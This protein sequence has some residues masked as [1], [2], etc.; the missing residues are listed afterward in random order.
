MSPKFPS[1]TSGSDRQ[2]SG[3]RKENHRRRLVKKVKSCISARQRPRHTRL[4]E[5]NVKPNYRHDVFH[6]QITK[7]YVAYTGPVLFGVGWAWVDSKKKK[8]R[9]DFTPF[10]HNS[11]TISTGAHRQGL[12]KG[13]STAPF[14]TNGAN[15]HPYYVTMVQYSKTKWCRY[16]D[17]AGHLFGTIFSY[18]LGGGGGVEAEGSCSNILSS[19]PEENHG[20]KIKCIKMS[21]VRSVPVVQFNKKFKIF[22]QCI[23]CYYSKE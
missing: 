17:K 15:E 19:L 5:E 7:A 4:P 21:F 3:N 14:E 23:H 11:G 1:F 18:S 9:F 2:S 6:L 8:K 13:C 10:F 12:I 22:I 16:C 20:H